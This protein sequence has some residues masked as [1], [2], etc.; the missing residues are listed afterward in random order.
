MMTQRSWLGGG[1]LIALAVL[2]VGVTLLANTVL[3]GW[4]VDL[5]Q[6]RLYTLAPGTEHIVGSLKE[7][8]NLYFYFSDKAAGQVPALRTYGARVREFLQEISARSH[9]KLKLQVIDPQPFSE[10]ED[11]ASSAGVRAMPLG[12]PGGNALY[13]GLAGTNSTD[14]K[15]S[16]AFFDPNKEQFLEYDV[17][18]LVQQLS[19]SHK[20]V[21][22]WLSS[23]SM[24]AGLDPAS[25]QQTDAWAV[26]SQAEQLF[27]VRPLEKTLS[28]IE[29]DV[30]VLVLVH[31]KDLPQP[32][33]QAIDQYALRGGHLLVF[34]D[35]VAEGDQS[36][37][38]PGNPMA[39]LGADRASNLDA[40]LRSWGVEFD[41][42]QSL[43]DLELGITVA[44]RADAQ[45]FRHIGILGMGAGN[46]S[47]SDVVTATLKNLNLSSA[48][49]LSRL[50]SA[51]TR[52]EPLLQT[53]SAA[54]PIPAERFAM[55]SDPSTLRDGFRPSGVKYNVAARVTGN[56]KSAYPQ[57]SGP[58]KTSSKPFTAIVVADTDMLADYMWVRQQSLF[59]QRIAQA[60]A[61]N[62]DFLW[63]ALDNLGG[64]NDL[65][66]VRGRAAFTR[67][68]ERVEA[69]RHS[70]DDRFRAKE[71]ELEQQL[72]ATE[73]K[74]TALETQ[75]PDKSAVILSAQQEAELQ[76]FQAQK[77]R[78]RKELRDVRL[79]LDQDITALSR[80]LKLLNI[81][82]API[83]VAL[84]GLL[85]AF[86][87]RRRHAAIRMLHRAG[88]MP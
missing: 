20:P 26:L 66:S 17:A 72:S 42:R 5:T 62:G 56:I 85:A 73:Q 52:F 60:W 27:T 10:D 46:F 2:F 34:V 68:F 84:V 53:S 4:R 35:P 78:I 81:V 39:Q 83:C 74:L 47:H 65:I 49:F 55:L 12:G 23:L 50:A 57:G 86:W 51:S 79:S 67:P 48:G 43:G 45:P 14:G 88:Q 33:L 15:A 13:F 19:N 30:D 63:N 6:N 77:L 54:A 87:K 76:R 80:R 58:L 70:A 24:A 61:N 40:L 82:I 36:A 38:E 71:Q 31:P 37:A 3:R 16:I 59:G 29:A 28:Q 32:A 8:V 41:K 7:Q 44:M 22:G 18:K 75:Q 9:G 1:G 69:L 11:R 64:S 25:G 21:V